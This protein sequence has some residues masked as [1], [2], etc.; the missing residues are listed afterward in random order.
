LRTVDGIIGYEPRLDF[1]H[2]LSGSLQPLTYGLFFDPFDA[3]D[4]GPARAIGQHREAVQDGLWCMMAAVKDGPFRFGKRFFACLTLVALHSFGCL[5][6]FA[7]VVMPHL[8][9]L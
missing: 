9:I 6:E 3:M 2:M 7:N 8:S 4:R 5:S 1:F